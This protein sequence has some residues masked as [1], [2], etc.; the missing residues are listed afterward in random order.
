MRNEELKLEIFA[1]DMTAFLRDHMVNSFSLHSGLKINF[2]KT[3][4]LFLGNGQKSTTETV[5]SLG[6]NRNFTVEK[7]IKILEVHFT[8]DQSMWRKLN[9][10]E[11]RALKTIKETKVE[12]LE[13]EKLIG[14]WAYSDNKI[15]CYSGFY[16]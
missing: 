6:S 2:E 10:D 1:D 16:V 8:Y 4:V 7:A 14:P 12:L 11:T 13:T 5:I 9:F 3:E 15:C